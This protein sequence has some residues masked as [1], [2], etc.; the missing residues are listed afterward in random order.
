MRDV[1]RAYKATSPWRLVP[2]GLFSYMMRMVCMVRSRGK[3]DEW[4]D[5]PAMRLAWMTWLQVDRMTALTH[6]VASMRGL[7]VTVAD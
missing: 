2:S 6:V 3:S 7:L 1:L 4:D 5:P